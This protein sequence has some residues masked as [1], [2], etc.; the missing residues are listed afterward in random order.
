MN[1]RWQAAIRNQ[2]I[3]YDFDCNFAVTRYYEWIGELWILSNQIWKDATIE[4]RFK[5]WISRI[6]IFL[7]SS[8]W[9]IA[10]IDGRFIFIS[11]QFVGFDIDQLG[12]FKILSLLGKS[13]N[14][15]YLMLEME[16][17]ER[18][19]DWG[20]FMNRKMG[21]DHFN[22]WYIFRKHFWHALNGI[23]DL[24]SI[25]WPFYFNFYQSKHIIHWAKTEKINPF[26]VILYDIEDAL[27]F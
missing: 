3:W 20:K 11:C 5:T 16:K 24:S 18:K 15:N 6:Q 21:F 4:F 27:N 22:M 1:C 10:A 7:F 9:Q 2:K 8:D 26:V 25:Y 13:L 23:F 19:L 17:L 12:L 14:L